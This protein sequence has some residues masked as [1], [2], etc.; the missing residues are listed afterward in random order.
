MLRRWTAGELRRFLAVVAEDRLSAMWRVTATTGMRKSEVLGLSWRC[1]DLDGRSL[2]V[3]QQIVALPGELVLAPP[4]TRRSA[5]TIALDAGTSILRHHRETQQLERALAGDG[6]MD[7]DLIFCDALGSPINPDRITGWF[8]KHRDAAGVP[9]GTAHTLRHT[10]A[11]TSLTEGVPLHIVAARL[12]DD[13]RTTLAVYSHLLPSSDLAAADA[14]A[15]I[16][17]DKPLTN[18]AADASVTMTTRIAG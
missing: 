16:L 9:S 17:V 18:E 11:T 2:R 1:V 3:E 7:R 4:K 13:P 14:I 6:Y 12:G 5:R 8:R 15:R 10:M